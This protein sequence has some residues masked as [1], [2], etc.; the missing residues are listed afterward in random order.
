M[1][2]YVATRWYRAPELLLGWTR[3]STSIDIW[4]LGCV[5]AE[6]YKGKPLFPGSSTLDQVERV[7]SWTGYPTPKDLHSLE[8]VSYQGILSAVKAPKSKPCIREEWF[9]SLEPKLKTLLTSM[10]QF[11]HSKRPTIQQVLS[12]PFLEQFHDPANEPVSQHP[13]YLDVDDSIK[14]SVKAYREK[15]W[16]FCKPPREPSPLP[17]RK[18]EDLVRCSKNNLKRKS[19]KSGLKE[20]NRSTDVSR[21]N[22]FHTNTHS[23]K[24][25]GMSPQ[26]FLKAAGTPSRHR[27]FTETETMS[28]K[29]AMS[30]DVSRVRHKTYKNAIEASLNG[31]TTVL[32]L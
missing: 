31:S 18:S 6:I 8:G 26:V 30:Q 2:E 16:R 17:Y 21:T 23:H 24:G 22:Y 10:L 3:Y 5:I 20:D 7:I 28:Q 27:R 15:I 9:V 11:N 13:I 19:I 4:S 25:S 29:V 14:L 32:K 1:T 12:H